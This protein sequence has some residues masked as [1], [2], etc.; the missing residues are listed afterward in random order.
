M[1]GIQSEDILR[2][3]KRKRLQNHRRSDE[4]GNEQGNSDAVKSRNAVQ[5]EGSGDV[6]DVGLRSGG[7]ETSKS[8]VSRGFY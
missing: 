6:G 8:G 2:P 7:S 3:S 5:A 4:S 1:R